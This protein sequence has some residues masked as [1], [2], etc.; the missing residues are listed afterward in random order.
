MQLQSGRRAGTR[1]ANSRFSCAA[2]ALLAFALATPALA[3]PVTFVVD[4]SHTYPRFSYSH[5]GLSTQL[6]RFNNTTGKVVLDQAARKASV[7]ITID[8]TSV[9]TGYAEFN[10]HIQA[11]DFLDT[12]RHPTAT[13]RST[14]VAFEGDRPVAID[15]DLTIKGITKPVTLAVTRF[16]RMDHPLRKKDAIGADASVV[17]KRSDFDAGQYAPL[18]GDEV[19]ISIAL[20]AVAE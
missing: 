16:A 19:T 17:I 2:A 8:M 18:V 7:E 13:F 3:E 9:D 11:E 1:R 12:A 4:G 14:R 5:L 10:E 20:E 15:G 6:S